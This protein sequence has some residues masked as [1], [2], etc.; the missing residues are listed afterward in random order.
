MFHRVFFLCTGSSQNLTV[1]RI[2]NTTY[3]WYKN[4]VATNAAVDTF[5]NATTSGNYYAKASRNSCFNVSNTVNIQVYSTPSPAPV[6]TIDTTTCFGKPLLTGKEVKATPATCGSRQDSVRFTYTGGTVGYDG[7]SIS[8]TNPTVNVTGMGSIAGGFKISI[9]WR[10]QDGGGASYCGSPGSGCSFNNEVKFSLRSP[11][12]RE[13][14][15]IGGNTFDGC[16][17]PGIVTTVFDDDG[18]T[19]VTGLTQRNG[20]FKPTTPLST[21]ANEVPNGT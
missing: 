4:N 6:A 1:R 19:I 9:T 13:I 7:G 5:Y 21:L 10:K 16:I 12:G 15:I 3:L 18:S 14:L 8:G 11:S 17:D 20:T 2:P